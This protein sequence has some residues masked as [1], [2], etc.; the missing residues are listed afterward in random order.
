MTSKVTYFRFEDGRIKIFACFECR[1]SN[2]RFYLNIEIHCCAVIGN[3]SR[4]FDAIVYYHS[5]RLPKLEKTQNI[6]G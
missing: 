6:T 2:C 1:G 5:A 3:K 4:S